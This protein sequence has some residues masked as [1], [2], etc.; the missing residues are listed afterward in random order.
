M[1]GLGMSSN[2]HCHLHP[3]WCCML[4]GDVVARMEGR[5]WRR[6][7][8]GRLAKGSARVSGCCWG[9]VWDWWPAASAPYPP[10]ACVS[11]VTNRRI[12]SYLIDIF[13]AIKE[14]HQARYSFRVWEKKG[15]TSC[16]LLPKNRLMN[17]SLKLPRC[18][19]AP[20]LDRTSAGSCQ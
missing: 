15:F 5:S 3:R 4:R 13:I 7:A 19:P 20:L 16:Y 2:R 10:S 6:K 8:V 11:K 17:N 14:L 1:E 12:I 18:S 9:S